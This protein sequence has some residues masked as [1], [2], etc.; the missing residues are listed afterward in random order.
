VS[1]GGPV[2]GPP[3][4]S[5]PQAQIPVSDLDGAQ[6]LPEAYIGQMLFERSEADLIRSARSGDGSAF[7]ELLRPEYTAAFRVAY[8]LL[9]NVDEAE[10]AVQDAAF[11]AWKKLGNVREGSPLRPWFLAIVANRCRT[12]AKGRWWSVVLTDRPE[13]EAPTTDVAAGIDLRRALAR[14]GHD[15]R[16]VLVLRYYL[17]MPYEEIAGVLGISPKAARTRV[18]RALHRVRPILQV[19]EALT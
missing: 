11:T 7:A 18:E 10:D 1:E 15:E 14:L 6:W 4:I 17:D 9:H 13:G 8:G 19:R 16:L 5:G 12:V 2:A 3:F